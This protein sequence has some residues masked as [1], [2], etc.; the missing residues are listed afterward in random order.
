MSDQM[1]DLGKVHK[2][3][4]SEGTILINVSGYPVNWGHGC[5]YI[6][7]PFIFF[8]LKSIYKS[9]NH[10]NKCVPYPEGVHNSPSVLQ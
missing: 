6:W 10:N 7:A 9:S 2:Y 1:S 4:L 5:F 8:I 3:I